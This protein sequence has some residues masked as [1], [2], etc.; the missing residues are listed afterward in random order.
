MS[1]VLK[2]RFFWYLV[3]LTVSL[4]AFIYT[5]EVVKV[6]WVPSI[7]EWELTHMALERLLFLVI[8]AI[9]AWRFGLR[10]G[11]FAL[12]AA[13]VIV[14]QHTLDEMAGTGRPD[15]VLELSIFTS[16]GVLFTWMIARQRHAEDKLRLSAEEWRSTFDSISDM[17]SILDTDFKI[18]RVNKPCASALCLKPEEL[19]GKTCYKVFHGTDEPPQDCPHM[20][21]LK[22]NKP[23]L[24]ERFEP[25]LG[26]YIEVSASPIFDKEGNLTGTVHMIKDISDR[27]KAEDESRAREA[28]EVA[29]RLK[30]EFLTNM[31][32]ELRTPLT[33]IIGFSEVLREQYFGELNEKQGEYVGDIEVSGRHLLSLINDILDL[34]KIEAGKV[35]LD[36]AKVNIKELLEDSLVMIKGKALKH[37]IELSVKTSEELEHAEIL[38]DERRLKQV[39]FNLLANAAKFT[40]DGGK[41][42]V[43]GGIKDDK[44]V[45]SVSDTGIGISRN[46]L[47]KIFEDF[48]QA[49]NNK[50]DK[51]P[52]T[53]LGLSIAKSIVEM[54]GGHIW[55]ESEGEGKGSRFVFTLPISIQGADTQ[56]NS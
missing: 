51:T 4:W 3:T 18:I 56:V 46:D 6:S 38:A 55:S 36:I 10:G 47:E 23:H 14:F 12:I 20:R 26:L 25:N 40:P 42:S 32:H 44:V 21:T 35:D 5:S 50:N 27:K 22:D 17:V 48:Y 43:E 11:L 8:V 24:V 2:D 1:R 54:H 33:A 19:I 28:A 49:K 29:N 30:S 7:E 13:G 45:V 34:S 53:G 41:V 31:S 9:A 15:F 52:G 39:M 16:V 37:S